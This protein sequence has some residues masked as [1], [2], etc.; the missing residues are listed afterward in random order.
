MRDD[1]LYDVIIEVL[2]FNRWNNQLHLLIGKILG[3]LVKHDEEWVGARLRRDLMK[4]I[5]LANQSTVGSRGVMI[6][7]A[8][9]ITTSD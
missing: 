7:L 4:G 5:S 2:L 6:D 8:N 1:E 3:R 9:S